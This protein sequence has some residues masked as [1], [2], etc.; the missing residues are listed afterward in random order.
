MDGL[1]SFLGPS[2]ENHEGVAS[3]SSKVIAGCPACHRPVIGES[4]L[5]EVPHVTRRFLVEHVHRSLGDSLESLEGPTAADGK[6][7]TEEFGKAFL[8]QGRPD[9]LALAHPG[10][11]EPR[12]VTLLLEHRDG[13]IDSHHLDL[14]IDHEAK[15]VDGT[16][17]RVDLTCC[18]KG[19]LDCFWVGVGKG[20]QS[21]QVVA[22]T[23]AALGNIG[24][25]R[26]AFT[27]VDAPFVH[28]RQFGC[29]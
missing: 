5:D 16:A 20:C 10:K 22:I 26:S 14:S 28:S 6:V 2:G 21:R 17:E 24:V 29:I 1:L 15:L 25:N 9:L 7:G 23:Q 19:L 3:G 27:V 12:L 4:F 11:V 18:N 13:V 8:Q